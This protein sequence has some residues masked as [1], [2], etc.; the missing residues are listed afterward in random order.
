MLET[1]YEN[2]SSQ[3]DSHDFK[4]R[5]CC[6]LEIDDRMGEQVVEFN[7][8]SL[9]IASSRNMVKEIKSHALKVVSSFSHDNDIR[10][11]NK[12][13]NMKTRVILETN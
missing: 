7:F 1:Q 12:S 6:K 2:I 5:I 8:L 9:N 4:Q 10:P 3:N 13:R 11:R